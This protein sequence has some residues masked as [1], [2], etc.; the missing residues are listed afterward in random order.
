M[1]TQEK[2]SISMMTVKLFFVGQ[3]IVVLK[4]YQK[5]SAVILLRTPQCVTISSKTFLG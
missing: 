1:E 5:V 3:A 2:E 4:W